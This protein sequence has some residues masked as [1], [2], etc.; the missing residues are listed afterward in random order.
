M[1][2]HYSYNQRLPGTH[3]DAFGAIEQCN[4]VAARAALRRLQP[5]QV[6]VLLYYDVLDSP[7]KIGQKLLCSL[8]IFHYRVQILCAAE[9]QQQQYLKEEDKQQPGELHIEEGEV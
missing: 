5:P 7:I 6:K 2:H 1:C 9:M 8:G 4:K 3:P